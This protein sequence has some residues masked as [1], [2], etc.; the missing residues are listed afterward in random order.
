MDIFDFN[1][2][3][4]PSPKLSDVILLKYF[5]LCFHVCMQKH[6]VHFINK[7]TCIGNMLKFV[8]MGER[9]QK[10]LQIVSL[11]YR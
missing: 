1:S 3:D 9:D 8:L 10:C 7:Y 6:M 5:C 11:D 2:L 4:K